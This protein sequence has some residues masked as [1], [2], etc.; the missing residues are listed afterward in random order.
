M[1]MV[2]FSLL[3]C[4]HLYM[5]RVHASICASI[6]NGWASMHSVKTA[7]K[8]AARQRRA[9]ALERAARRTPHAARRTPHAARRNAATPQRFSVKPSQRR[10]GLTLNRCGAP[11]VSVITLTLTA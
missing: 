8:R 3:C 6:H 9:R 5:S 2:V 4:M 7:P 1:A 11:D 10:N